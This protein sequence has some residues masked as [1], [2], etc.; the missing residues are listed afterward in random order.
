MHRSLLV[1]TSFLFFTA[2]THT[3]DNRGYDFE[4][5]DTSRVQ[6]GQTKE[7]VLN[8]L[9]SPSTLST[10]KDNAWYYVSKKTATKSFFTP[11]MLDQ[12]LVIIHFNND[13]VSN[14]EKK[15]KTQAV[16]VE[17]SKNQTQ[18]SGYESGVLRE[19]FGNFGKF[20]SGKAPTKS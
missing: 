8:V 14:I 12:K 5:V 19:V 10:F 18:T 15:D 13:V 11:E 20:G 16:I 4:I 9:G 2:C 6:I 3:I 7:Q 1:P 17:P